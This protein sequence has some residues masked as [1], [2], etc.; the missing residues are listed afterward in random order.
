MADET[1]IRIDKWLWFA[2][3][4]KSR[5]LAAKLC[6]SGRLRLGGRI[7]EKPHHGV[8]VGDVLTFPLGDAIRIVRVL[9]LGIRRGTAPEARTLFEDLSP[10]RP[11]RQPAVAAREP[12]AG[13][14]TK[15]D[16][17]AIDRLT[18]EE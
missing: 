12:G 14:P 4:F 18:D 15:A 3:F 5:A 9:A 2:R 13:R 6:A 11:E 7:V 8:K 1:S 17:R 16:R 10:P